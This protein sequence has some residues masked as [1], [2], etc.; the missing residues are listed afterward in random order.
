V[1][2]HSRAKKNHGLG[3]SAL[4]RRLD[5]AACWEVTKKRAEA[6]AALVRKDGFSV[7]E[8]A[9]YLR[10]DPANVSMMLSRLSAKTVK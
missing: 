7:T 5:A 4:S 10:R 8:V 3:K 6:V 9:A 2:I 1:F